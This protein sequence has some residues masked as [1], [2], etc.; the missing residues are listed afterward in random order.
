MCFHGALGYVQ[1]ASD[2]RIVTALKQQI[3]D[4]PLPLSHFSKL[5]FHALTSTDALGVPQV[6]QNRQ[7]DPMHTPRFV[8]L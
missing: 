6:A 2:F 5:L 7:S 8:S 4:L 3:D 1:I